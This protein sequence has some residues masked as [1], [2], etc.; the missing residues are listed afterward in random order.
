[1]PLLGTKSSPELFQGDCS[2]VRTFLDHYDQLC[3]F[4][5]VTSDQEMVTSIL[6]Y[7]NTRVREIIEGMP[8]FHTPD[9]VRLKASLLCYFD[10]DIFDERF[11]ERDLKSLVL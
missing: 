3:T 8:H 2:Q 4:H 11:F 9:W 1:M 5:N 10:A 7:C 6:Q